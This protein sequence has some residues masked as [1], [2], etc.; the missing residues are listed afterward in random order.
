MNELEFTFESTP[1]ENASLELK[2]GDLL[3]AA[4]FL[5]LMEGE[6]EAY[7]EEVLQ[8]LEERHVMLDTSDLPK[9][10]GSGE[11]ALRL[12]REE[13]L[14]KKGLRPSELEESDPL[15]LYLEEVAGTP[16]CGDENLLAEKCRV[17]LQ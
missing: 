6:D 5:A 8:D 14:A 17:Y 1:W 4:H 2:A 3:S 7:L 16:V 9:T 10:S 15:R 13:Q 11:A 12:R